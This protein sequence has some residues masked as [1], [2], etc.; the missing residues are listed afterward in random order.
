[1]KFDALCVQA[2][3][4]ELA[5]TA[6]DPVGLTADE[7]SRFSDSIKFAACL[8]RELLAKAIA[9]REFESVSSM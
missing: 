3:V 4:S 8:P 1:V 6:D 2:A 9:A 7:L 5:V